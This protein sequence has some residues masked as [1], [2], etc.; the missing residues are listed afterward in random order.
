MI[1]NDRPVVATA[2]EQNHTAAA[3]ALQRR[4]QLFR[5]FDKRP[6]RSARAAHAVGHGRGFRAAR[7][8]VAIPLSAPLDSGFDERV[9]ASIETQR[10]SLFF[11][12][13]ESDVIPRRHSR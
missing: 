11:R 5:R 3:P 12:G 9:I 1:E 8:V 10:I 2:I 6:Q 13:L 7:L 4:T